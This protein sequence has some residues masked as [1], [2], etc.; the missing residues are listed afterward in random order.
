[1]RRRLVWGWGV[2]LLIGLGT[3]GA[4]LAGPKDDD[5][6]KPSDGGWFSGWF[7]GKPAEPAKK[8]DKPDPKDAAPVKPAPDRRAARN[9]E[10]AVLLRRLAVCDKL[11][12]VALQNGD[13]ELERQAD[14]LDAR[15]WEV[16]N[17]RIA[18]LPG[19]KPE[20][21][22]DKDLDKAEQN[23][24]QKL[25]RTAPWARSADKNASR[26]SREDK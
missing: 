21:G 17:Q 18:N 10:E 22:L 1:M 11:K 14:Q 9:R 3:A 12:Q 13:A 26:A 6:A 24:A 2:A 5:A 7:G 23:A 8:K 20:E 15:A 25:D 4:A 16:Y 19:G